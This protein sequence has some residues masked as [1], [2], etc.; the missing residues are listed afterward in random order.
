M[1]LGLG[2]YGRF[3]V[4][5]RGSSKYSLVGGMRRCVQ[6]VRYEVRLAMIVF[7]IV[8]LRGHASL[9]FWRRRVLWLCFPL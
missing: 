6:R 4:G 5:L 1:M 9:V 3:L 8:I 2:V 7:S